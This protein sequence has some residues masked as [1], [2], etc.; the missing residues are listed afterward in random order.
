MYVISWMKRNSFTNITSVFIFKN[1]QHRL[2]PIRCTPRLNFGDITV[3]Y[4]HERYM[5]CFGF[6]V[7][8]DDT[9]VIMSGSDLKSLIKAVNPET[10]YITYMHVPRWLR[11]HFAPHYGYFSIISDYMQHAFW[12]FII[13][14][15]DSWKIYNVISLLWTILNSSYSP[16]ATNAFA[17]WMLIGA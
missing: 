10:W 9:S 13:G 6:I 11:D 5:Q 16:L 1:T 17:H 7:H 12:T 3:Y 2:A 14:K 8:A 15:H 4:L